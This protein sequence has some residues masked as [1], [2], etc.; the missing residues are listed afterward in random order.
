MKTDPDELRTFITSLPDEELLRI[1]RQD[2]DDYRPEALDLAQQELQRRSLRDP[3]LLERPAPAPPRITNLLGRMSP[4]S[5]TLAATVAI[6]TVLVN[7]GLRVDTP[8]RFHPSIGLGLA[9]G[10]LWSLAWDGRWRPPEKEGE[11][12]ADARWPAGPV[13][14][15]IALT[16]ATVYGILRG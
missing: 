4:L 10:L 5:K 12:A 13:L 7:L 3:D 11:P 2:H 15:A 16:L 8:T 9:S 14:L 1:V 6:Y